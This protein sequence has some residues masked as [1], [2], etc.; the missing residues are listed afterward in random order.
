MQIPNNDSKIL[1]IEDTI[2]FLD[3]KED[4]FAPSGIKKNRVDVFNTVGQHIYRGCNVTVNKARLF[5]LQ[6]AFNFSQD[7]YVNRFLIPNQ[8]ISV[9]AFGSGGA[10]SN[11]LQSPTAPTSADLALVTPQP[12]YAADTTRTNEGGVSTGTPYWGA[13]QYKDISN[14]AWNYNSVT[15]EMYCD[16]TLSVGYTELLG[17]EMNEMGLFLCTHT[18]DTNNAVTAKNNFVMFTHATFSS[19]PKSTD[20][21]AEQYTFVYRVYA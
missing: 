3:S 20:P 15:D 21:T 6:S 10:P 9:F 2:R 4:G 11:N 17:V 16:L 5:S 7:Q 14:I 8:W 1:L 13:T 18:L 12:F 19:I